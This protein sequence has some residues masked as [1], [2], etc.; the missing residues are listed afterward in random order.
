MREEGRSRWRWYDDNRRK[1]SIFDIIGGDEQSKRGRTQKSVQS[2][3]KENE[4]RKQKVV[5]IKGTEELW[6]KE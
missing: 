6:V 5:E 3:N 1:F 4:T 2:A